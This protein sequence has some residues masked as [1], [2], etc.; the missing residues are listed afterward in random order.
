MSDDLSTEF[1]EIRAKFKIEIHFGPD[2]T[3]KKDFKA[4]VLLMESGK[5]FHGGGDGQM[6]LCLDHRLFEE[7]NTTPPSVLPTLKRMA[8][9]KE[10]TPHGCGAP[11]GSMNIIADVALCTGCKRRIPSMHLTGQM[12]FYGSIQELSELT[13]LLFRKLN[14]DADVYCKYHPLDIRYRTQAEVKGMEEARRL[15]GAFLYPLKHIIQDTSTGAS[16]VDRFTA[17]FKA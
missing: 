6:Y 15:R 4:L 3:T 11:I 13:E 1:G 8:Q 14:S 10:P 2:R 16:L 5:F 17:L 12:P 9:A 7:S